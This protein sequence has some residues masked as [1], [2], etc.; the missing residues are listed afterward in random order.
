MRR[1]RRKDTKICRKSE[2]KRKRK[3]IV[4]STFLKVRERKRKE[5]VETTGKQ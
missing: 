1:Q 5:C 3:I 4:S 2:K